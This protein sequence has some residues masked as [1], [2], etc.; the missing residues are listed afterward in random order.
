MIYRTV[1][2]IGAGPS[3]ITAGIQLTR[4]GI[5]VVLIEGRCPG[6]LLRNANWVE[7]YEAVSKGQ[8]N[9]R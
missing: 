6:G 2:I 7:N 9:K 1:G 5:S 8:K 3:G 4:Y